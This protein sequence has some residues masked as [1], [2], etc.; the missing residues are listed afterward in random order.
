MTI[1]IRS[2]EMSKF[3]YKK[4]YEIKDRDQ[5]FQETG[6][7]DNNAYEDRTKLIG[8]LNSILSL[9]ADNDDRGLFDEFFLELS[10][11]E[12]END[13]IECMDWIDKLQ[14]GDLVQKGDVQ[15]SFIG[16]D[17]NN[18]YSLYSVPYKLSW[19]EM[20]VRCKPV[21]NKGEIKNEKY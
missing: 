8:F 6:I 20:N 12:Q 1:L 21:N 17:K 5:L 18:M 16:K 11:K 9:I 13:S 15:Y 19:Y 2:D 4:L 7:K 3:N 10:E 14:A